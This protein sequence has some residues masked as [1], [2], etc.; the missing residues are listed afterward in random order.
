MPTFWSLLFRSTW[1]TWRWCGGDWRTTKWGRTFSRW[2]RLPRRTRSWVLSRRRIC[3]TRRNVP[4]SH[5]LGNYFEIWLFT[6][7]A[8]FD[9]VAKDSLFN[10]DSPSSKNGH[11]EIYYMQM[12]WHAQK[13]RLYCGIIF[14]VH[15]ICMSLERV[16][17]KWKACIADNGHIE[18]ISMRFMQIWW[19][20]HRNF[21][22]Y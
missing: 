18:I 12:R 10:V 2:K 17:I 3:T 14:A 6:S 20:T 11:N 8:Y 16:Y 4:V 13:I 19:Y 1:K 7:F 5:G 21:G 9:A 22:I 15:L